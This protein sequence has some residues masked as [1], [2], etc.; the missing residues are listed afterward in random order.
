MLLRDKLYEEEWLSQCFI[1]N[2]IIESLQDHVIGLMSTT[3]SYQ[4]IKRIKDSI[5]TVS[6]SLAR[7]TYLPYPLKTL[8]KAGIKGK[9]TNGHILDGKVAEGRIG[10]K[11]VNATI[12]CLF[13]NG[14]IDIQ[15]CSGNYDKYPNGESRYSNMVLTKKG[16]QIIKLLLGDA[17][18]YKHLQR[19]ESNIMMTKKNVILRDEKLSLVEFKITPEVRKMIK[20]VE[21]Y[22]SLMHDVIVK[23]N[24]SGKVISPLVACRIFCRGSFTDGGRFY[25]QGRS[26]QQMRQTDRLRLTIDG[27]P[28]VE[29]DYKAIHIAIIDLDGGRPWSDPNR[30]PYYLMNYSWV[31]FSDL[32]DEDFIKRSLRTIIK[33]AFVVA[34]NA[35]SEDVARYVLKDIVTNNEDGIMDGI[36][37]ICIDGL[38]AELKNYHPDFEHAMFSGIG[39]KLQRVDSDIAEK[40]LVSCTEA[41][42]PVICVHDS[43]IVQ[44]QH[45]DALRGFMEDAWV[46]VLGSMDNCGIAEKLGEQ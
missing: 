37:D 3:H 34:I 25:Y 11:G 19:M 45:R 35:D 40:V 15:I 7:M 21:G 41:R 46:A 17:V 36:D 18:S 8:F 23:D 20:N 13:N 44:R 32:V 39:T 12:A 6:L 27:D 31:V 2:P 29:L 33:K 43:F 30:D 5:Y 1:V 4:S 22:N 9:Y 14:Y 16:S 28:V 24:H 38:I 26:P 10:L 42:I